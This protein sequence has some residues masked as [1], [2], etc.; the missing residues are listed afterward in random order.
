[1]HSLTLVVEEEKA[2]V[3]QH[4][5]GEL[6]W[7]PTQELGKVFLPMGTRE[8]PCLLPRPRKQPWDTDNTRTG[9]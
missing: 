7:H 8:P 1:M 4:L 3:V 5:V 9:R 2:V 6:P